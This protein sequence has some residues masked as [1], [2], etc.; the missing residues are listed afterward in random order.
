MLWQQFDPTPTVLIILIMR[1]ILIRM[2]I[3]DV[4]VTHVV[5]K[6]D[7]YPFIV[8]AYTMPVK[9]NL[10]FYEEVFKYVS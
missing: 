2:R 3:S 9:N 1:C 10:F 7:L 4:G 5:A 8:G 6:D